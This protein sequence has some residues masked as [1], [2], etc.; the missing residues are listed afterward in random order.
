MKMTWVTVLLAAFAVWATGAPSAAAASIM[1]GY[2]GVGLTDAPP[3]LHLP[4]AMVAQVM[5]NSP[6]NRAGL[7]RG[8]IIRAVD[9]RPVPGW[10]ALRQYVMS[11]SAGDRLVVDVL[12]AGPDGPL[13][14]R[15]TITLGASPGAA[16]QAAPAADAG[17]GPP[18]AAA[19]TTGAT[20]KNS[21]RYAIFADPAEHAFTVRVPIGWMIGGRL[22]RY[23]PLTIAGIVQALAPDGSILVQL[24][25][26]R[27]QDFSEIPGFR[28]GQLYTPGTSIMIIRHHE[29]ARQYAQSYA[30]E[31]QDRLS[32]QNS[33][34][35]NAETVPNPPIVTPVSYADTA[36]A[37]IRFI[38][39]R[40]N[41][42]H[43]GAVLTSIRT[44]RF[45]GKIGWSVVY[46]A[47]F[48]ARQDRAALAETVWNTMRNSF[49]IDPAWNA[50]ESRIAAG[51]IQPTIREWNANLDLARQFDQHVINGEVTVL[52]PTTGTRS[53]IPIGSEP[54]YYSDGNGHFYNSYS[55]DPAPGFHA[56]QQQP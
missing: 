46:L 52:D 8:D 19:E 13:A 34:T 17:P 7:R 11:R 18:P 28:E 23:G 2:L 38:C 43:V 27:I 51:A 26:P 24:G 42:P 4:A 36:S 32:C 29:T 41:Q 56:V 48:L 47:S 20:P 5:P 53:D 3:Q 50:R 37:L 33:S 1:R 10:T 45:P 35:A 25:D 30:R 44:T 15:L 40:G 55:A 39:M 22:V 12:R 14:L 31:L 54:Y 9:G 16:G 6:A 49:A 21:P